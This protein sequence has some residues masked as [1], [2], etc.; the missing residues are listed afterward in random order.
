MLLSKKKQAGMEKYVYQCWEGG[1]HIVLPFSLRPYWKG[2]ELGSDPLD[3]SRDYGRACAVTESFGFIQVG[4]GQALVLA[5]D[6][7]MVAWSPQSSTEAIDLFIL[8]SWFSMDLDSLIDET[9][10]NVKLECT[11]KLWNIRDNQLGVY[12]AGDN[13]LDPIAGEIQIPCQQGT[14]EL[15]MLHCKD[16]KR[17]DIVMIRLLLQTNR[18]P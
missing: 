1:P 15:W 16:E 10:N 18:L 7:P 5:Q 6:P 2:Y 17:G 3:L 4:D 8:K 11:G 14:Y 9:L 12:Y 13:P